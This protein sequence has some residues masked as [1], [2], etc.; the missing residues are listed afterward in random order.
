MQ[1]HLHRRVLITTS[2]YALAAILIMP[3]TALP[4]VYKWVDERG[5]THYSQKPPA[6]NKSE[7]IQIKQSSSPAADNISQHE[8]RNRQQRLLR[9]Y[10]E[11]RLQ[12]DNNRIKEKQNR[13][14][15]NRQCASARNRLQI[16]QG[17]YRLYDLDKQGNRV[18]LDAQAIDKERARSAREVKH[19]CR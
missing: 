11:E 12:R 1:Q 8:H 10:E 9:A 2:Y 15:R 7:Q 5:R 4:E 19:L 18:Y 6:K 3:A 13:E 14:N 16:V 17:G